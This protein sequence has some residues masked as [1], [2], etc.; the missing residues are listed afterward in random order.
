MLFGPC[1][2]LG[3]VIAGIFVL[4]LLAG[5]GAALS[6]A[7]K[8]RYVTAFAIALPDTGLGGIGGF[9]LN[10]RVNIVGVLHDAN[11]D[12]TTFGDI[13]KGDFFKALEFQV[14]LYP[15]TE[16]AGY[17]L[18]LDDPYITYKT[19][20][21]ESVWYQLKRMYDQGLIYQ[22]YTI[23][24]YSPAAGTGLSTHELNQPG[25]YRSV[26]D[27]SAVAMFKVIKDEKSEFLFEDDAHG[28]LFFIAWSLLLKQFFPLSLNGNKFCRNLFQIVISVSRSVWA[29]IRRCLESVV[30]HID[31]WVVNCNGDDETADIVREVLAPVPGEILDDPWRNFAHNRRTN[32]NSRESQCCAD[33]CR[34]NSDPR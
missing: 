17:W 11:A 22:G 2:W 5:L 14:K 13:G 30:D 33:Y 9:Y 23:Q 7:L 27:T 31:Y 8:R 26:K 16:K 28:D 1:R 32:S 3:I 25:T 20:Y 21:I 12:R 29:I 10:D 24:P 4:A 6:H 19:K 15:L 34:A 18:D